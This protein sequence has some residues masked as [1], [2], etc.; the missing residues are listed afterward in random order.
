MLLFP[1]LRL[2]DSGFEPGSAKIHLACWNGKVDPLTEF[3]EG[4]FEPWQ[5]LQTRKNFNRAQVLALIAMPEPAQWL[6]AGLFDSQGC[7]R[8]RNGDFRYR[9]RRRRQSQDLIGRL[10][11]TFPRPGRQSYLLAENWTDDIRMA[12][13]RGERLSVA[14]FPGYTKVCLPRQTLD[15]IVRQEIS[16]WKSA[17]SSVGGVYLITDTKTGKQYVGSATGIGGIWGR[18]CEYSSCGHGGNRDLR[19]L[20]ATEGSKHAMGFQFAIL[21]TADSKTGP[22]EILKREIHW[23]NVLQTRYHG[24]NAN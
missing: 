8:A 20:L 9:L 21:E 22:E 23:K 4:R 16:S 14:E 5:E 3:L 11:A 7:T 13:I 12:Q 10:V 19:Q 24:L 15:T 6:F 17:L 2:A 1:L 18:W